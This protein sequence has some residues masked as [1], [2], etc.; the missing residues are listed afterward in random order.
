MIPESGE[1]LYCEECG[2]IRLFKCIKDDQFCCSVCGQVID[3]PEELTVEFEMDPED[4][5]LN[6]K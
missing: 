6:K 5:W 4:D 2:C 3:D 1:Y